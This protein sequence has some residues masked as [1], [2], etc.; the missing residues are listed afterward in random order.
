[1]IV[2]LPRQVADAVR[3]GSQS[4]KEI[5]G[6]TFTAIQSRTRRMWLRAPLL[7][8]LLGWFVVGLV[9]GVFSALLRN[10]WPAVL[11]ASLVA[12]SFE[13]WGVGFLGLIG[14]ALYKSARNVRF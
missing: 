3:R 4:G 13:L 2:P 11:P 6:A 12:G 10:Y 5:F 9:A 7:V 8:L 14:I 1:V